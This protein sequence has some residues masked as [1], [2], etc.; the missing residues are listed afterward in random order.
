M[1]TSPK[2]STP[3]ELAR[4]QASHLFFT[5]TAQHQ[6]QP[7]TIDQARGARFHTV[8]HGWLWDLESQVYNVNVGHA[9]PHVQERMIAQIRGQAT[10]APNVA[11]PIRAE[12]GSL[13]HRLTGLE[14]AF[15]ATG[16]S[17]AVENAIKIARLVTGRS[18]IVTRR[19]SYHG[20]T[21]AVLGVAGDP[22]KQPF[23]RDLAPAFHIED[24][25]PCPPGEPSSW[26]RSLEEVL[27]REDPRSVA[28]ILLEGFTG[29]N[30]MQHPP[31]DFWPQARALCDAHGILLID[32]EIFSG[33]GRT[34]RWFA[35]EHWGVRADMMVLGKGLTSGYAPLSGVM[36]S[37]AIARHFDEHKLWCGLTQYAHPVSCA[38]AVGAIEVM[39]RELLVD[40]CERI[41]A[42]LHERL[43]A[44][45][46]RSAT[47]GAIRDAR[48][49]GLMRALQF[50]R[51]VAPLH[52]IL[53]QRGAYVP[54]RGDTLFL[55]P[56]LCL[57]AAEMHTIADL[58]EDG[59]RQFL[60]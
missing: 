60:K 7:L 52:A 49:L 59:V 46:R 18:K 23:E 34:G 28:A 19:N 29:T 50:D 36:V 54:F 45:A 17:E 21:L 22:R 44:L 41:G 8:E 30:G 6:A 58:L 57:S 5:W 15:L 4:T 13:L 14:K 32:D 26:V 3:S 12:L 38:A 48:G 1:T 33:F 53:L 9:H 2:S 40:N 16:G 27:A 10:A 51:P 25:Y 31:A 24:P 56:P 39:E 35:R 55:C 20:A 11:L 37:A 47:Q 42:A 43:Q